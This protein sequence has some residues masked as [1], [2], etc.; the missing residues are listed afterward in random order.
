[1]PDL[2]LDLSYFEWPETI[3]LVGLLGRDADVLPLRLKAYCGRVHAEDGRLSGLT[4]RE[5]EAVFGW[6]G[7]PGAAVEAL[8]KVGFLRATGGVFEVMERE[9]VTWLEAQGHIAAFKIRGRNAARARWRDATSNACGNAKPHPKQCPDGRTDEPT[10]HK[11]AGAGEKVEK[12][13]NPTATASAG[14]PPPSFV[15]WYSVYPRRENRADAEA[16]WR[17]LAP[18]PALVETIVAAATTQARSQRWTDHVREGRRHMIPMP[19]N[20]LRGK[21]WEDDL[22]PAAVAVGKDGPRCALCRTFD[23]PDPAVKLC[24]ACAW[25]VDCDTAGRD[26]SKPPGEL[27]PHPQYDG[28]MICKPCRAARAPAPREAAHAP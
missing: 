2:N 25:C 3:R 18:N 28:G 9:G 1:M 13:E 23:L 6:K 4:A 14:G 26:G 10:T 12:A 20:W 11:G 15:R 17:D 8:V 7:A 16:A 19:G 22:G 27:L 24:A 5:V 21:R